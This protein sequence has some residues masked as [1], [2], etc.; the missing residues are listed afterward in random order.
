MIEGKKDVELI[1]ECVKDWS[2]ESIDVDGHSGGILTTWSTELKL[3]STTRY[4]PVWGTLLEDGE[5]KL[6]NFECLW[7]FL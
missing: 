4:D 6:Y 5:M 2:M 1:N 3:I 7:A